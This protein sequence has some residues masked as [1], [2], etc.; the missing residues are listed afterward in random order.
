MEEY[1]NNQVDVFRDSPEEKQKVDSPLPSSRSTI[2][3]VTA[4]DDPEADDN[5]VSSPTQIEQSPVLRRLAPEQSTSSASGSP[6]ALRHRSTSV[7][8]RIVIDEKGRPEEEDSVNIVKKAK[9]AGSTV[10]KAVTIP[11]WQFF[12]LIRECGTVPVERTGIYSANYLF[13]SVECHL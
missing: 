12:R 2:R 4:E 9:R 1:F 10:V 11:A 5:I 6:I 13:C 8:Q 7:I 3:V